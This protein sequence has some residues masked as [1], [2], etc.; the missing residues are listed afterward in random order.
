MLNEMLY[1]DDNFRENYMKAS[2]KMTLNLQNDPK[3]K[4]VDLAIEKL[5]AQD[6]IDFDG[7]GL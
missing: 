6:I 2:G 5:K 3:K 7:R 4:I 1:L